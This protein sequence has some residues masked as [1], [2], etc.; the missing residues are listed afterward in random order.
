MQGIMG[1]VVNFYFLYEESV[2]V[3][4]GCGGSVNVL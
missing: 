1:S 4:K 2:I 3:F